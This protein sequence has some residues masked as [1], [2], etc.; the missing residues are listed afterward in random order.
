MDK[1]GNKKIKVALITINDR[2]NIGNRLQNYAVQCVL[3]KKDCYVTTMYYS[4]PIFK[5]FSANYFKLFVRNIFVKTHLYFSLPFAKYVKRDVRMY[6]A[7]KFNKKHIKSSTKLIYNNR[8]LRKISKQFDKWCVGSDQVWNPALVMNFGFFFLDF[9]EKEK[10]FSLATSFGTTYIDEKYKDTYING[11]RHM[12]RIS[13]REVEGKKIIKNLV[14][15]DVVQIVDPTMLI[16]KSEWTSIAQ[17]PKCCSDKK[18]IFLYFLSDMTQKQRQAIYSYADENYFEVID[19]QSKNYH[20][21]GPAE[22]IWCIANAEFVFTDSFH[23]SVFSILFHKSFIV[24]SRNKMYDMSSRITTLL[25]TFN[26]EKCYCEISDNINI[27]LP[28]SIRE[29]KCKDLEYI[30][31]VLLS[32]RKRADKFLDGVFV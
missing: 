28:E 9:A 30:D 16:D 10:T 14:D 18:F 23:G 15:R 1:K 26:L 5:R 27:T 12:G 25:N 19:A 31:D 20:E 13:V 32:E 11:L 6:L 4:L 3:E 2:A 21:I 29:I 24:F 17:R 8:K 22:F 7:S